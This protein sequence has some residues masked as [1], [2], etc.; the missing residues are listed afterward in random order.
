MSLSPFTFNPSCSSSSSN[1]ASSSTVASC[2]A[3]HGISKFLKMKSMQTKCSIKKG[4]T[5]T[6]LFSCKRQHKWHA[7]TYTYLIL[8]ILR[9]KVIQIGLS[10]GELHLI[11][12]F[13]GENTHKKVNLGINLFASYRFNI[14]LANCSDESDL[15]RIA[16]EK[17]WARIKLGF[18]WPCPNFHKKIDVHCRD[19]PGIFQKIC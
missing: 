3:F 14:N 11:H 19:F 17:N 5:K 15:I 6:H 13:A 12:T 7:H 18:A 8:L 9:Y 2:N 4:W 16:K 1:S 10:F